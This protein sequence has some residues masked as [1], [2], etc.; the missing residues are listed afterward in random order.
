[1]KRNILSILSILI[2]ALAFGQ[3][4]PYELK[5]SREIPWLVSS[6]GATTFGV[7][8]I[9][10]KDE[11]S[12][13]KFNN[14]DR[15]D[16]N[17]FDRW[18]A[19]NFSESAKKISDIPFY[20]SFALP[21]I[22]AFNKDTKGSA[23]KLGVMYLEA[24]STTSAL[25]TISVGLIERSRPLVYNETLDRDERVDKDSQRSFYSGHVAAAA[26]ASFF[27]AQVFSDFFPD[28]KWKPYVWAGAAAIPAVAGYY[29]IE[30]GSH[31]LS[32]V[33]L[34]Y[35]LGAASVIP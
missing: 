9:A 23:G 11:L 35:A 3:K 12:D 6:F 5:A 22:Y 13:T 29:R 21:F 31:F 34:G 30:G 1:M 15:N 18:A 8:S 27:T 33:I 25:F 16:V 17:G 2:A 28:S 24:L 4:D 20:G 14:L 26:T 19:G 7:I 10:N 32:D